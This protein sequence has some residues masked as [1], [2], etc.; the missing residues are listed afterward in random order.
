MGSVKKGCG[1]VIIVVFSAACVILSIPAIMTGIGAILPL[2]A[3]VGGFKLVEWLM[4]D[5][6]K[7]RSHRYLALA[8]IHQM[9][10]G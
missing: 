2:L 10:F 3:I 5:D 9:I 6:K 4:K 1:I 7:S 8:A